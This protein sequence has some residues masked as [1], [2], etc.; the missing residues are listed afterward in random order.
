MTNRGTCSPARMNQI[1][2]TLADWPFGPLR[3]ARIVN[4]SR[5]AQWRR[6]VQRQWARWLQRPVRPLVRADID[7][8]HDSKPWLRRNTYRTAARSELGFRRTTNLRA[9][10]DADCIRR[11][12]HRASRHRSRRRTKTRERDHPLELPRCDGRRTWGLAGRERRI[13]L[14]IQS[15]GYQTRSNVCRSPSISS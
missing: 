10:E 8:T 4:F 14:E 5:R 11:T 6:N 9:R 7:V 12:R 1:L 15:P 2:T 3:I 13:R